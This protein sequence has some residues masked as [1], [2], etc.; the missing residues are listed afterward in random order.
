LRLALPLPLQGPEDLSLARTVFSLARKVVI[1]IAPLCREPRKFM[2][3][4]KIPLHR[5]CW[6][7][8]PLEL[9]SRGIL[10][11]HLFH[12]DRARSRMSC[13]RQ[14]A[15]LGSSCPYHLGLTAGSGNLRLQATER[16]ALPRYGTF[17]RAIVATATKSVSR[18]GFST[19]DAATRCRESENVI[20]C[21]KW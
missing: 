19:T 12:A 3:M 16:S 1:S 7:D 4:C 13:R 9:G 15:P 11:D 5:C 20:D 14:R 21:F 8:K 10:T 17:L 6:S 18:S 2:S